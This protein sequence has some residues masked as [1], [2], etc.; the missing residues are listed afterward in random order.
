MG[1]HPKGCSMVKLDQ[2]LVPL[3]ELINKN[4]PAYLSTDI[5]QAFGELP[6]LFKILAAEKALSVQ[7]HPNKRQAEVGFAREEQA[8]IL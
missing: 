8:R 7:V 6:F 1:A 4:K 2:H 3:S 5:A